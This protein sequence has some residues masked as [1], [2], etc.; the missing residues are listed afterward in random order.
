M[1]FLGPP[2]SECSLH[3]PA[4]KAMDTSE[5]LLLEEVRLSARLRDR[6]WKTPSIEETVIK[7]SVPF[8]RKNAN[9]KRLPCLRGIQS[10]HVQRPFLQRSAPVR[11]LELK[12]AENAD[13]RHGKDRDNPVGDFLG[14]GEFHAYRGITAERR[15]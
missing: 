2:S 8:V 4:G 9:V 13:E 3:P 12:V 10:A 15:V 6:N 7:R 5:S 11:P 14:S 1:S